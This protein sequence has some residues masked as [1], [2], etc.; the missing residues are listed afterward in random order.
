MAVKSNDKR[1]VMVITLLV[2]IIAGIGLITVAPKLSVWSRSFTN[3][4][5]HYEDLEPGQSISMSF[6]APF[7]RLSG[8][9]IFFKG[10]SDTD[11]V[12]S[13]DA[14]LVITDADGTVICSKPVSS[15][16]EKSFSFNDVELTRGNNYVI[17]YKL[18]SAS[19]GTGTIPIG[20]TES[21]SLAFTIRGSYSG[22]Q[23][24]GVFLFFYIVIS[25]IV[26]LY[27]WFFNER[28]IKKT[29]TVDKV[30]LAVGLFMAIIVINQFYDLFMTGKSGLRMLD[31][32]MNGQYLHYYDYVYAKELAAGSSS[33]FFEYIY[34][35]FT[36]TVVAILMIPFRF[37]SN[38]DITF[39][40][41]GNI[42][43]LYFD[44]IVTVLVL[45]SVKLTER[46]CDACQMPEKYRTSVK[47]IYAFSSVVISVMI[48]SGQIDII[49]V[50]I[51]LWAMPFYFSGKYKTFSFVM[52]FALAIKLLP[53]MVFFPLILLTNKKIKDIAVNSAIC[54]SVTVFFK[55]SDISAVFIIKGFK[56]S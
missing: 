2:L 50:I 27:V 38:G 17:T 24:K 28:D 34:S 5:D 29:G 46:I 21:G 6:G 37:I 43:V 15:V 55:S 56:V 25:A 53:F 31:A 23:T 48:A 54:L 4:N 49:Y 18:I 40:A 11:V 9:E 52:A 14:E 8:V 3:E 20:V 13:T 32:I 33:L 19:G 30:I 26:L 39:S 47:Y 51:M 44:I 35:V 10:L 12:T 7:D 22:A 36:Y 45:W 1:I 41:M 42:L 16:F